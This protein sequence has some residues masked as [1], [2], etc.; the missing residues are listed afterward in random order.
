[1]R[2]RR[3][4]DRGQTDT[5]RRRSI[6]RTWLMWGLNGPKIYKLEVREG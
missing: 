3:E 2:E 5:E 6:T 4:V 1:M